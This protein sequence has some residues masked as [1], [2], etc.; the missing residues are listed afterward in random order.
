MHPEV[1]S[2]LFQ[3]FGNR[4]LGPYVTDFENTSRY[5]ALSTFSDRQTGF[6]FKFWR[7]I[8]ILRRETQ[9]EKQGSQIGANGKKRN[10]PR[11][12]LILQ[13]VNKIS[14]VLLACRSLP[15]EDESLVNLFH[16]ISRPSDARSF[17]VHIKDRWTDW[18][19]G[20]N[21][22]SFKTFFPKTG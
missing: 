17:L 9:L 3:F 7:R 20:F 16:P 2:A 22:F 15:V 4:E 18:L 12:L 10:N 11:T 13:G 21:T 5:E 6:S 19:A 14:L 8:P 1:P